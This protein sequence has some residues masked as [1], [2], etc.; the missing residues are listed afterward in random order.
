MRKV[1]K[2][3]PA[4]GYM[5]KHHLIPRQRLKD[6][7]GDSFRMPH[8]TLRLWRLRHDAWHVLFRQRTINEVIQYLKKRTDEI[9]AYR[10]KTWQILFGNKSRNE[11]RKLLIRMRRM[12][13]GRYEHLELDPSLRTKVVNIR[14]KTKNHAF[15]RIQLDKQF[16]H[17]RVARRAS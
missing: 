17:K 15:G 4:Y 6:Y 8:N 7:Y 3:H 12:K 5:S 1:R 13:R 10:T 11:A 2:R 9:Y 14:K 16:S